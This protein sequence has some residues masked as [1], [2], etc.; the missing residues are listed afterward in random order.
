MLGR[1]R[2]VVDLSES[3]QLAAVLSCQPL[4]IGHVISAQLWSRN[5]TVTGGAGELTSA[6]RGLTGRG[7]TAGLLRQ[8]TQTG[9]TGYT[10]P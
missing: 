2:M 8:V 1:R 6:V 7:V 5:A 4:L 3:G 9:C 10:E